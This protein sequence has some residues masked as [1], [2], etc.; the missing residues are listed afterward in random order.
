MQATDTSTT[1]RFAPLLAASLTGCAGS[2]TLNVFGSFFPSWMLCAL[3]GL[4]LTVVTHRILAT[5]G[6]DK[7]VP[8]PFLVYVSLSAAF[9]FAAW[10]IWLG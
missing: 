3:A 4:I 6:I 1:V 10:L 9:T 2:P 8:A 5:T 7:T